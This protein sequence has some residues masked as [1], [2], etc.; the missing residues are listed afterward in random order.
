MAG[1]GGV[2]VDAYCGAGFFAKRLVN[3]FK[4][5]V[6][7]DW[8]ERSTNQARTNA[9]ANEVYFTG[10]TAELLPAILAEHQ[11]QVVLLDPPAQGIAPEVLDALMSSSVP[12]IIYVSC[13][14]ATLSRDIGKLSASYSLTRAVPV[15]MFPQTASIETAALLGLR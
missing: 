5:I 12:R 3:G 13:D 4:R 8:D 7:I 6:G 14:P 10:D 15:D 11:P 2:L 9:G 1:S